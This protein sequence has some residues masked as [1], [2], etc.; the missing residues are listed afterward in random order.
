MWSTRL[1]FG[2]PSSSLLCVCG[3]LYV[4]SLYLESVCEVWSLLCA[5]SLCGDCR[6][7]PLFEWSLCSRG[8][9]QT[10]YELV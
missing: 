1:R 5:E 2:V 6:R 4:W 7:T 9:S 3:N 10:Q 8:E